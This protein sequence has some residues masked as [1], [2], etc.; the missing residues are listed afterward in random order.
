MIR[1]GSG[2]IR[3]GKL[4]TRDMFTINHTREGWM[5]DR[6]P[7]QKDKLNWIMCAVMAR[8]IQTLMKKIIDAD[9]LIMGRTPQ[10]PK[11]CIPQ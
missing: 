6:F 9:I 4:G 1:V 7:V 2:I 3:T 5:H 8:G 11:Y 10:K